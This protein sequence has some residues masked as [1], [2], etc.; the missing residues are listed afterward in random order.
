MADHSPITAGSRRRAGFRL[1]TMVLI[2]AA[3]VAVAASLLVARHVTDPARHAAPPAPGDAPVTSTPPRSVSPAEVALARR[4]MRTLPARAALPQPLASTAA[5]APIPLPERSH[6]GAERAGAGFP[7]TPEGAL[8]QLKAITERGLR[9]GTPAGYARVYRA[10]SQPHAPHP[11]STG[12]YILLEDVFASAELDPVEAAAE[13]RSS[14]QVSHG[15]IKGTAAEGEYVVA[16]VLGQLS[17]Q[18]R[19]HT[20]TAG[21]GDCQALRYTGRGWLISSGP[22]AAAAPHAWPG[23]A[24][25]VAAGYRGLT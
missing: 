11:R 25:S 7:P 12:L 4:P 10:V 13:F 24:D 20:V 19:G 8:A 15:Q 14:Y 22:L 6:R 3:L 2:V 5:G 16:C 21:V 1:A 23:S 18:Y 9:D 17:L